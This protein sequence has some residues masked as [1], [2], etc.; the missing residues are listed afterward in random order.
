MMNYLKQGRKVVKLEEL[1][2]DPN[3]PRLARDDVP[4]YDDATA[5]FDDTMREKILEE[6]GQNIYE[7]DEL[8]TAIVGQG[9]LDIDSI[10][11]WQHPDVPDRYVVVEGNRRRLAL[12]RIHTV[13]LPRSEDKLERMKQKANTFSTAQIKEQEKTVQTLRSIIQDTQSLDV[14]ELNAANDDEVRDRLPRVLSTRHVVGAKPWRNDCTDIWLLNRYWYLFGKKYSDDVDH[15]WDQQL[16]KEVAAE[17]SMHI[18]TAGQKLRSA[19][20]FSHFKAEQAGNLPEGEEF[21][22][23]DYFLFEQISGKAWVKE[24]FSISQD[25]TQIS[26]ESE[27]AIFQ[28]V[29]QEPRGDGKSSE[30]NPNKFYRHQ[31]ISLWNKLRLYDDKHHT[32]FA[33]RFDVS[34]PDDAPTMREVEAQ[35]MNHMAQILPHA[36]LDN[37]I[38]GL[39]ELKGADLAGEGHNFRA[40]LGQIK[41]LTDSFIKMIDS[42]AS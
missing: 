18:R 24:Q 28:W 19:S 34:S 20:W 30:S 29:F 32:S 13:E 25:D 5:L 2:P 26:Q 4:G 42:V 15:Y 31:N 9:W 17:G 3:N 39:N 37:V 36:L 8:V 41:K 16:I 27:T 38:R 10:I 33:S 35:Y 1:Y 23:S 6:L 11:V 14:V 21:K 40:Q 7:V 12:H 22:K